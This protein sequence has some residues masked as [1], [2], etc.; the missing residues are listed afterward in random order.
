MK[1]IKIYFLGD[2]LIKALDQKQSKQQ[3]PDSLPK[4][5]VS[6]SLNAALTKAQHEKWVKL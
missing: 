4:H 5:E 1:I 6:Y 2:D 3:L